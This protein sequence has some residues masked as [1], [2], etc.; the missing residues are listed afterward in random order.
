V[1]WESSQPWIDDFQEPSRH[2]SEEK[3]LP[4]YSEPE[5]RGDKQAAHTKFKSFFLKL[6]QSSHS[7]K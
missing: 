2:P 7:R 5:Y 6:D 3:W 1:G 4:G